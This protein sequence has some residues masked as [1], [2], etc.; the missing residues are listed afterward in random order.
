MKTTIVAALCAVV[1]LFGSG[2]SGTKKD[3][4][5]IV[6]LDQAI[7]EPKEVTPS[8]GDLLVELLSKGDA[9]EGYLSK[10]LW[11]LLKGGKIITREIDAGLIAGEFEYSK[12]TWIVQDAG[13]NLHEVI[14]E[15][16]RILKIRPT[17]T[18]AGSE[19][20]TPAG[21]WQR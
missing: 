11:G 9:Q 18:N 12:E 6:P 17:K 15:N 1:L 7:E 16:G 14:I 19:D 5:T 2:C 20:V 8:G 21:G 10:I 4:V 13:K 3:I